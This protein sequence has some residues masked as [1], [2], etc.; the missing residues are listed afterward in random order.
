MG[1][2]YDKAFVCQQD[3][4]KIIYELNLQNK[5]E[6]STRGFHKIKLFSSI[7]MPTNNVNHN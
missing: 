5:P 1:I 4:H 3:D 2:W 7:L 6:V